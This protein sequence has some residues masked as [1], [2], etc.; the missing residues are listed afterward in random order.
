MSDSFE[1]AQRAVLGEIAEYDRSSRRWSEK[2]VAEWI[3]SVTIE[4][5]MSVDDITLLVARVDPGKIKKQKCPNFLKV[6]KISSRQFNEKV[7]VLAKEEFCLR[8]SE[9]IPELSAV[10]TRRLMMRPADAEMDE[11]TRRYAGHIVNDYLPFWDYERGKKIKVPADVDA[12]LLERRQKLQVWLDNPKNEIELMAAA[13]G[14]SRERIV[15]VLWER[16][17]EVEECYEIRKQTWL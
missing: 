16:I 2:H 6:C 8:T 7:E 14:F 11:A 10:P 4:Y 17:R 9:N 5:E 13:P 15:Q 1:K 3:A 12:L